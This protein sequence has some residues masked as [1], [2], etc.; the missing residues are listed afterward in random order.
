[1]R[2]NDPK[3]EKIFEKQFKADEYGGFDGQWD[4]PKDATLGVY[5]M[6]LRRHRAAGRA[7][8]ASRNT[9]SPSSR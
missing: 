8:S 2:I 3:G 7:R 6:Y 5:R 4:L 9:R 1:M